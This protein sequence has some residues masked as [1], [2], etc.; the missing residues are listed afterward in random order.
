MM[1]LDLPQAQQLGT[2]AR[3]ATQHAM[4]SAKKLVRAVS[5]RLLDAS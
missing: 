4:L 1:P 2:A 3:I 5:L